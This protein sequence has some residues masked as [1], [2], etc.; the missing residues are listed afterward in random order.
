MIFS[1]LVW[2]FFLW[3][4]F[5][6]RLETTLS[7]FFIWC[8]FVFLLLFFLLCLASLQPLNTSLLISRL[9]YFILYKEA[10]GKVLFIH[11]LSVIDEFQFFPYYLLLLIP[12]SLWIIGYF[13]VELLG[14]SP[15]LSRC[16]VIYSF[17]ALWSDRQWLKCR[18]YS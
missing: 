17:H 1:R 8:S 9:W 16:K 18:Q 2:L 14:P 3:L 6:K 15:I 11:H 13:V 10:Q 7:L 5:S 4:S 12:D